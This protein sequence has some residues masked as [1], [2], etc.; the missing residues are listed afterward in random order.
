MSDIFITRHDDLLLALIADRNRV[1]DLYIHNPARP[2]L[3]SAIV[4]AKVVRVL[5]GGK[6]GFVKLPD[7]QDGFIGSLQGAKAGDFL[8]LSV[9]SDKTSDKDAELTKDIRLLGRCL[10][11]LP[12]GKGIQFSKRLAKNAQDKLAKPLRDLADAGKGGWIV[13]HAAAVATTDLIVQEANYLVAQ[14]KRFD[15]A[16]KNKAAIL[17]PSY[18]FYQQAIINHSLFAQSV[19]VAEKQ[20]LAEIKDWLADFAPDLLPRL[21]AGSLPAHTDP[22]EIIEA[23]QSTRVDMEKGAWLSIERTKAMTVIDVNGGDATSHLQINMQAVEEIARQ[24]RLRNL[25]GM[26]VADVIRLPEPA[27]REK[28]LEKLKQLTADDPSPVDVLGYSRLGLVEMVR[29]AR[30]APNMDTIG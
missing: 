20:L 11:F 22:D 24:I 13:R 21:R 19:F 16:P 4:C 3:V 8:A 29:H 14:A 17:V 12:H 10:I 28:V 30:S 2:A 25:G 5:Q 1:T 7:G 23:L 15:E 27:Q 26:I 9:K 18:T 6:S